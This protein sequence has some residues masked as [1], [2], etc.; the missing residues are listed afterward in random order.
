MCG[1]AGIVG[2]PSQVELDAMVRSLQHRGPDAHGVNGGE[3]WGFGHARLSIIDLE[4]GAQPMRSA[5]GR[6]WVTFN[7]EIYNY[8]ELRRRLEQ[9]GHSFATQSDTE[10]LL[11][12]YSEWGERLVEHLNGMF[13]FAIW[14]EAQRQLTLARDRVGIKPLY[15][16][17][18]EERLAFASEPKALLEHPWVG[19]SL[20][21]AA[22][23]AYLDLGYVPPPHSMFRDLR[24]LRPG[25]VLTWRN[26]ELQERCY[27]DARPSPIRGRSLDEWAEEIEPVLVDAIERRLLADVP[28]GAFLSGGLDSST[29][30]AVA[31]QVRASPLATF[32][33]GY[34]AEGSSFDERS[35]AR[36]VSVAFGT[37]HRE[38]VLDA[39]SLSDLGAV[40][41]AFDEPFASP[42]SL[43][44]LALSRFAAKSV[45]VA[46]AGDGGDEVFGGY[47]RY[48][49]M[50][51]SELASRLPACAVNSAR[52]L[53]RGTE[54]SVARSYR[55][56][57]RQ[58]L[59]GLHRPAAARY[60]S[61]VGY[62]T[63]SDRDALLAP[64]ITT[65]L[66]RSRRLDPVARAFERAS[67]G[68]AIA[69]A[70]YAD[71]H[72]FLPEN[73]LR[74]SDRMSMAASLEVRVPFCDH[75]LVEAAATVPGWQRISLLA[76]K[77]ILRRIASKR[78][79][80]SVMRRSK[81]GFNGPMGA[82][83]RGQLPLLR[84]DLLAP[85]Q[86][87]ARG[88]LRPAA[89]KRI[90]DEH[91]AGHRDHSVRLWSLAVLEQWQRKYLD[92]HTPSRSP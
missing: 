60:A 39:S 46:L 81:L 19:R 49:G 42:T 30:V 43:L 7:G 2:S 78:L 13:A 14:D 12:G 77:R 67:E 6:I 50:Q 22:L 21:L 84:S 58:F 51:L 85:R 38:L 33:V 48:R 47:P 32:S 83:M 57:A 34:G 61:W 24:Q 4:T 20:N 9:R 59:E 16:A 74:C 11:A 87:R 64:E 53:L 54:A 18:H 79:P 25:H 76:S 68:D 52:R 15:Y 29:I 35:A 90:I 31:S 66:S 10:V 75:R 36:E 27:W 69:R 44:S 45:K 40:V 92:G 82:W 8:K 89:V 71:L 26:G 65:Q 73:V 88:L 56:W 91:E 80:R 28:V 62:A 63:V 70:S 1:I 72:G 41:D 17:T 37:E 23:D 3:G 5:C 86:V 55:R